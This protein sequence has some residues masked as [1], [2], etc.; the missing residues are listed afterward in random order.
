MK[1]STAIILALVSILIASVAV[2]MLIRPDVSEHPVQR[3]SGEALV[4][5]PFELVNGSGETVTEADFAGQYMLIYFGFTFCPDVCPTE[6]SRISTAMEDLGTE[7]DK[8]TPI[9]I[10]IDPE[11]DTPE[12]VGA[13]VDHFHPRMVGLTGTP[14]QIKQ[15]A[16]EYRVYYKKVKDESSSAE[17]TMDHTSI[18]YLMGPDGKFLTHFGPGTKPETMAEEISSY[19]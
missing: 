18:I 11:R 7:A 8:V 4:G 2:V 10:T 17:Y 3:T 16:G 13:Y 19:M 5:G 14:D 6:L 15:V 9:F 12:A 1:R